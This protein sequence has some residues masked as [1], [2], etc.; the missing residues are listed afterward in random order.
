MLAWQAAPITPGLTQPDS[1][2]ILSAVVAVLS[3][4]NSHADF[5]EKSHKYTQSA[6]L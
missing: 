3:G 1:D 5:R 6:H 4:M 2:G